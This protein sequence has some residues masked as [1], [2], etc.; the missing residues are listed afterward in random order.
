M[1]SARSTGPRA[2]RRAQ[3]RAAALL[4]ATA[5][6]R[7]GLFLRLDPGQ[8][9]GN[10]EAPDHRGAR[11]RRA[12]QHLRQPRGA[13]DRAGLR[14]AARPPP[15]VADPRSRGWPR[16][17]ARS[18]PRHGRST[19]GTGSS[20]TT[21]RRSTP[22][23]WCS[24]SSCSR[25]RRPAAGPTT[26]ATPPRKSSVVA[27]GPAG[28]ADTVRFNCA[29]PVPTWPPSPSP[30]CRSSPGTSGRRSRRPSCQ[31]QGPADRDRA[32]PPGRLQR[33]TGYRFEA[34]NGYF[35]GAP[36]VGELVMPVIADPSATF[37]AHADRRDRRRPRP[38]P[39]ELV[40]QSGATGS[41]WP[42]SPSS[43]WRCGSTTSARRSRSPRVAAG[44]LSCAWTART[45]WRP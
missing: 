33:H 31:G 5:L 36:L 27:P 8:R 30:T 38:V 29:F 13:T 1:T 7:L 39:P 9:F 28:V 41:D 45:C 35:V 16:R 26:S 24:P 11:G 14:Q 17:S 23:T 25:P 22:R 4:A 18:I 40:N 44:D 6:R 43:S 37:T 3:R 32:L 34:N 2:R 10:H 20:G 19:C 12:A 15:Y 21:A 42:P